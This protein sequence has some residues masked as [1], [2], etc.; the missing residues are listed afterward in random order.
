MSIRQVVAGQLTGAVKTG[1]K[2]IG[3]SLRGRIGRGTDSSDLAGLRRD[4]TFY[5]DNLQYPENVEGDP[6]Q[7]HYILFHINKFTSGKITSPPSAGGRKTMQKIIDSQNIE[8]KGKGGRSLFALRGVNAEEGAGI[9]ARV[10][11]LN[12]RAVRFRETGSKSS[13]ISGA[14]QHFGYKNSFPPSK[15]VTTSIALYMPPNVSVSYTPN[16]SDVNVGGFAGAVVGAVD[17]IENWL[18]SGKSGNADTA[19]WDNLMDGFKS[20]MAKTVDALVP[21]ARA[22]SQ[23]SAGRIISN[24]MELSFEGVNRREFNYTFVF[25]PKSEKEAQ[26]IEKIIWMFKYHSLPEFASS[27]NKL[28]TINDRS[29]TSVTQAGVTGRSMTIPDSF[30]IEYMYQGQ[31]NHMLNKISTCFCTNV[32][33]QYGGDRFTAYDQTDGLFGKGNPPQRTTL[34]LSFKE[35]EIMTKNRIGQGF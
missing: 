1:I 13:A 5:T 21:G 3:N 25:I 29:T 20:G 6:M 32:A 11:G 33:V 23:I 34:T 30:D 14:A 27:K 17:M 8:L 26:L 4:Y 18:T 31:I 24:K 7:G 10:M 16:Y 28:T 9:A 22:L 19:V 15:R 2:N 35:M 12:N